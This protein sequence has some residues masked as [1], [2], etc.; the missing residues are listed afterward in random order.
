MYVVRVVRLCPYGVALIWVLVILRMFDE[1]IQSSETYK[2][3]QACLFL[4]IL[5][6]MKELCEYC[7]DDR[8]DTMDV[9][10][11][12][13]RCTE[14]SPTPNLFKPIHISDKG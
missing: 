2:I 4:G 9:A 3:K 5:T 11:G 14:T 12:N 7:L 10:V 6:L 8:R 13:R 1:K